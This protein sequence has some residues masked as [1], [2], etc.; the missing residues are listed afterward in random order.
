[1]ADAVLSR[2]PMMIAAMQVRG[3]SDRAQLVVPRP[4]YDPVCISPASGLLHDITSRD[5]DPK[6]PRLN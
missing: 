6:A 4:S 1:M 3:A 2:W 5:L